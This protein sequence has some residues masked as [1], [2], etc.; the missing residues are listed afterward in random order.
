MS[1]TQLARM[2]LTFLAC[3]SPFATLAAASP[4]ITQI[5][6]NSSGIPPGLPNY[7]IAPSSI[8][9]VTGT[10]LADTGVPAL[11]SSAAP[12]LPLKLN[13]ASI[14]VVVNGVTTYPALYYTSPTQLAAVLPAAT[15][16]GTGTLTVT[17]DGANS[18]AASIQMVAS[19]VGINHFNQIPIPLGIFNPNVDIAVATDAASGALLTFT[20]SGVPGEVIT[21]WATGLGADAADSDTTFSST[22]HAVNTPLKIY[23]G[24][25]QAAILYQGSAGY[26]GVT[27]INLAIPSSITT[28]C[29]V[30]LAAVTGTII[31][32]VVVFPVNPGGGTCVD[33][34]RGTPTTGAQI[35][36]NVQNTLNA[37]A[38]SVL[39]TN[40]TSSKDVLTVTNSAGAGFDHFTGLLAAATGRSGIITAGGCWVAPTVLGGKLTIA[41][42]DA[43]SISLT[44]PAGLA[45]ALPPAG[46]DD[47]GGYG[48]P[49]AAGAIPSS[50]GTFTFTGTGGADVGPF[51]AAVT[52]SNPIFNWTNQGAAATIVRAQGLTVTWTGGNPGTFVYI[53]GGLTVQPAT[54]KSP[55]LIVGCGCRSAVEAGQFTVPAYIFLGIPAGKGGMTVNNQIDLTCS[56]TGL[57]PAAGATALTGQ[58]EFSMPSTYQ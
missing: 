6:N 55:G 9:I 4:T 32:N 25:V 53:G 33:P 46:A 43:G 58:I 12:G 2:I 35:L 11:Q 18:N 44:G 34:G 19:A 42:L 37:G 45:I 16:V 29:Y 22:P 21:L 7:G 15:P 36:Q 10:G 50:G 27:Q 51:N 38:L 52:F 17:Y 56:A 24:G 41:G 30:S 40:V 26:P 14:T 3:A 28:G 31:S 47:P 57:D 54:A 13:G 48:G 39:Q 8:F 49:L 1:Q 23:V 5:L 20:N